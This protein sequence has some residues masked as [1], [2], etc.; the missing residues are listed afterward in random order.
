MVLISHKTR[1]QNVSL[2]KYEGE[3]YVH[4]CQPI[5]IIITVLGRKLVVGFLAKKTNCFLML[6]EYVCKDFCNEWAILYQFV[7]SFRE[8]IIMQNV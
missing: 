2:E 5:I 8:Q 7:S 4:P 3:A 6:L 1:N